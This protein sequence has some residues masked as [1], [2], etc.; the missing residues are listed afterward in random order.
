MVFDQERVADEGIAR[1]GSI[2]KET[3]SI[4]VS[5][6]CNSDS[7]AATLMIDR[8]EGRRRRGITMSEMQSV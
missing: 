1:A 5:L 2:L 8:W 7:L 6:S 3:L 4:V